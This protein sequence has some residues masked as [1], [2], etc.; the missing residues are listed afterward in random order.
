M[1]QLS[2]SNGI[3]TKTPRVQLTNYDILLI[4]SSTFRLKNTSDTYAAG[5]RRINGKKCRKRANESRLWCREW[6]F[7]PLIKGSPLPGDPALLPQ[8][9]R[10]ERNRTA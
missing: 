5:Q 9:P 6:A 10:H 2:S 8:E 1:Q 4:N 7:N 3:V